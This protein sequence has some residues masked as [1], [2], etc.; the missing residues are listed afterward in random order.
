MHLH[1]LSRISHRCLF[2]SLVS[3]FLAGGLILGVVILSSASAEVVRLEVSKRADLGTTGY[4]EIT[5]RLHYEIDPTQAKNAVIADVSLAP[6]NAAGR[7]SFSSDVRIM[8][9]KD[10]SRSNGAAWV[11]IP[12]RGGKAAL[13]SWVARQGF[14]V[15]SVGWEFD[16]PKQGDKMRIQVPAAQNKD[17]TAIRGVVSATFT[18]D[19]KADEQTLTDLEDYPPVD[20]AG[21]ESRLIVRDRMAYAG[22]TEVA[23]DQWSL[24][25]NRVRLKGGFEPGKTYEIFYLAEAP[26]VAGL[27][28][29]A[30]RDAVAW[31]KHAPDSPA[32]V[33]HAYAFGSSQCGRFL[34][35]LMYLGFNTDE[36]DQAVFDGVIA[37]I[38]GAGRLV[39]NR[40]WVTP[41]GLSSF[42]TA[43]Y[44]FADTAQKDPV[45]GHS[46]GVLENARVKHAPK[47]FYINTDTEY[48]GGGRVAALTHTD[49]AGT[50][51]IEFPANVRSYFLAGTQ[52]GPAKFPPTGLVEGAPLAN[53]V[54]GGPV[55]AALRLAMHEWV[56]KGVEPPSSVHPNLSGGTLVPV[57][58]VSFP[59]VPGSGDPRTLKAGKR[60][61]NP[62]YSDGAGEGAELPLLVPQ[63]DED[64]NDLAG[65]RMPDVAVPLGTATGWVFRPE[66]FGSPHELVALRGAWVPFAVTKAER[67]AAHD[68]RPAMEERY[69][70]KEVYL[71]KV[72]AVLEK[73]QAQRLLLAEDVDAQLKESGLRWDW[74]M[75]RGAK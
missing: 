8:K 19:K 32:P 50:R 12:N 72:K 22:G 18:L 66:A 26:P 59:K 68:P 16:V 39:L 75:K 52:H 28:F 62:L 43:S 40:R 25:G 30:I 71:A 49:P 29:A 10:A 60:L 9:P 15:L 46:E 6:V 1:C 5:G 61:P 23:R 3:R 67:E 24:D 57:A 73:L 53:P 38:A 41:R 48:W 51:D 36:Q 7:V 65:I 4:E 14:T 55:T 35:E 70:S 21:A 20:A 37:H 2:K 33:K 13:S 54:N 64:G 58:Q 74:V 11:E 27:G 69:E 34:R 17:G 47:V 44:P 31:L 42:Y 56:T 45:S 63:V